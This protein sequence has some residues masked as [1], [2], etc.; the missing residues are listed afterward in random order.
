MNNSIPTIWDRS[1]VTE[2]SQ[3]IV[4]RVLPERLSHVIFESGPLY[5][6]PPDS[7]QLF[8]VKTARPRKLCDERQ[9]RVEG[10]ISIGIR[11]ACCSVW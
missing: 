3:S 11:E 6:P 4:T 5:A 7:S 1:S 8:S 10:C 9:G 2:A